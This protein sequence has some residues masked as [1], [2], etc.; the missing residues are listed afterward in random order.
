VETPYLSIEGEGIHIGKPTVFIRLAE[1]NLRCNWC[2]TKEA[3]ER[4]L[5]WSFDKIIALINKIRCINI[6]FT[7]G[8]PLLQADSLIVLIERLDSYIKYIN[9]SG[10]IYNSSLFEK[11][12]WITCDLKMPKTQFKIVLTSN[13][14]LYLSLFIRNIPQNIPITLQPEY[15]SYGPNGV[16]ELSDWVTHNL[17]DKAKIRILP[18]LHKLL[19]PERNSKV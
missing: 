1:C 5:S 13:D 7:G 18:Q 16:T 10:T 14:L 17:Q 2:D 12:D 9:T 3:W 11:V 19:W 6:C 8:E 15:F 4:G